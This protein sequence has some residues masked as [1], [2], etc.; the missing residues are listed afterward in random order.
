MNQEKSISAFS[1]DMK[2]M[3]NITVSKSVCALTKSVGPQWPFSFPKMQPDN[4][5]KEEKW[6]DE[7]Q[8]T[9]SWIRMLPKVKRV[10]VFVLLLLT[11]CQ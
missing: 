4:V 11:W 10:L 9:S 2:K 1:Q 8:L 6:N 7:E 5:Y 3:L